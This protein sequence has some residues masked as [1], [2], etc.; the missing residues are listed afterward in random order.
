MSTSEESG[1][2]HAWPDAGRKRRP[3]IDRALIIC[4]LF[5]QCLILAMLFHRYFSDAP[6]NGTTVA[7]DS[8]SR[9]GDP[10]LAPPPG[11][12]AGLAGDLTRVASAPQTMDAEVAR[13]LQAFLERPHGPEHPF[14]HHARRPRPQRFD[15][16]LKHMIERAFND[17]ERLEDLMD[18]D[19]GWPVLRPSPA[20]DMRDDENHYLVAFSV[21]GLDAPE[22]TVVLE[23]RL[24]TISGESQARDHHQSISFTKR[25]WLPGPV[26]H[27]KQAQARLTN[28]ILR[29]MV[30]KA[31]LMPQESSPMRLL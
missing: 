10:V 8:H 22:L 17:I 21:P 27:A 14:F 24:L 26:A 25:V 19:K 15:S 31:D 18:F 9:A 29:V 6:E 12:Q 13:Y 7:T 28:G 3:R 16:P 23:G 11:Y 30:P 20:M 1:R 5:V 4:I 2:R